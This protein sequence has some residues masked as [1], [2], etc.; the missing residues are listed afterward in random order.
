M[1]RIEDDLC[2]LSVDTSG[3]ALHKRG[4][5]T[6]TAKAPLRETLAALFLR[7]C[8]YRG[9]WPVLDPM[10]G[11]GSFVIEAAEV[12]LGLAPGRARGFAFEQLV[13]HDPGVWED[14]RRALAAGTTDLRFHGSDRDQ[15]AIR[16]AAANAARAGVD[17]VASFTR[18]AVSDLVRPAGPPGLVIVNPPYGLRIGERKPLFAVHGALGAVLAE[19]FAGWR[20]GM[21]TSDAGLARATGLPWDAPGPIVDHGGIKVRLWQTGPL[22]DAGQ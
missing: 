20:V 2:T 9:Q 15:G 7:S 16:A 11:S 19:R 21:V 22:Q 17:G 3:E 13:T 12:A 18:A 4:S 14:E 5:K 6:A 10:C 1:V 8:G